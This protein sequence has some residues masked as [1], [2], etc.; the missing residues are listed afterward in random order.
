M[1]KLIFLLLAAFACRAQTQDS[2]P[3]NMAHI[4]SLPGTCKV[5]DT[6]FLTG[7]TAGQNIYGCTATNTWTL[8]GDG[9]GVGG[10]I[11]A[12]TGDVTASGSGSVAGT[13]AL[14]G[15][16]TAANVHAGELLANAATSANTA[17][18]IMKRDGSG[19]F[20]AGTMTGLASLNELPLTFGEGLLRSTNTITI[21]ALGITNAMLAGAVVNP[22][23]SSANPAFNLALG[24]T[25]YMAILGFNATM[26]VSNIVA[27][28]TYNFLICQDGTG[29]RTFAWDAAVHGGMI[30]GTTANK[31]S[32]QSFI[33]PNNLSLYAISS[34][35]L[36]Q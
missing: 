12:L 18:T 13:V 14:V 31:C 2:S 35:T 32:S 5:G 23:A 19:N 33:A 9:G 24:N 3:R 6:V 11:T 27:G 7:V 21:P 20:I 17:N 30:I 36:N 15:T 34:A 8:Q 25:Q 4:A 28:V 22:V 26:T 10:G 16:S 1:K 29:S